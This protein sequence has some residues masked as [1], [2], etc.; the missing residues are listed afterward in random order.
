MTEEESQQYD[1]LRRK[2]EAKTPKERIARLDKLANLHNK[3][4]EKE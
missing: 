2:I 4:H 1:E 3:R